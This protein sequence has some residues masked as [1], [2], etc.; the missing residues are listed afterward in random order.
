MKNRVWIFLFPMVLCLCLSAVVW[1]RE[2]KEADV[3]VDKA[4]VALNEIML[5]HEEKVILEDLIK[6]SS[7]IIVIPGM[8]KAGF[9]VGG[10][11]GKGV[12]AAHTEGRWTG[13]AFVYIGAGSLGLQIG[14]ESVDLILVVF[15]RKTMESLLKAKFKL[16][17]DAQIAAGPSG[18]Q[19][20]AAT[21]IMLKG[22]IYSYSRAKGA[23]AGISLEGAGMGTDFDLN[24][25]YYDPAVSPDRILYGDVEP[26]PTGKK[27]L[28]ELGKIK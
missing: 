19:V 16:G 26:P 23:F 21:D 15:G 20:A 2:S 22:G 18:A 9:L 25:A 1:A 4:R 17:V 7:G 8:L 14:V 28:E 11:Y 12:V 3:I 5:R 13:P 6:K 27:F 24:R 10:A